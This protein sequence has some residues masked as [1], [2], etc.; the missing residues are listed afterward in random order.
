MTRVKQETG[1]G[2]CYT[3]LARNKTFPRV[4]A[5]FS[6]CEINVFFFFFFNI[7]IQDPYKMRYSAVKLDRV[8]IYFR[9][10]GTVVCLHGYLC[11]DPG[12]QT[13]PGDC[14]VWW[15]PWKGYR[16]LFLSHQP[17]TLHGLGWTLFRNMFSL[18]GRMGYFSKFSLWAV[19]KSL[20]G[21]VLSCHLHVLYGVSGAH[22]HVL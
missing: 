9:T 11:F 14:R 21:S 22:L 2:S 1:W 13:W 5:L 19:T 18:G 6:Y 7:Q 10:A 8:E 15:T 4:V 3:N 20:S 17:H 12:F 16:D